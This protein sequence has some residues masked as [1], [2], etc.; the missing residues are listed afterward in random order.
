MKNWI[1]FL[2]LWFLSSQAG[3]VLIAL[4]KRWLNV[5]DAPLKFE[6]LANKYTL[7]LTNVSSTTVQK[8][9]LGCVDPDSQKVTRKLQIVT[10]TLKPGESSAGNLSGYGSDLTACKE[11]HSALS[12][13][14]VTFADGHTWEYKPKRH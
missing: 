4:E 7:S 1:F 6:I 9:I 14:G 2:S 12:V 11:S 5:L 8:H 10:V 3:L 13:I